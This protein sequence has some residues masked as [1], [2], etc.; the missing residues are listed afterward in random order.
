MVA[1][2]SLSEYK[3]LH[4]ENACSETINVFYTKCEIVL[5]FRFIRITF[6]ETHTFQ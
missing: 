5:I 2:I 6:A 3:E 1:G 4:K